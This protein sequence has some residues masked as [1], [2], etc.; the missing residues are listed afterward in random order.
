MPVSLA[1]NLNCGIYI[2]IVGDPLNCS[3]DNA[4]ETITIEG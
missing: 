1:L 2:I 3:A 4:V